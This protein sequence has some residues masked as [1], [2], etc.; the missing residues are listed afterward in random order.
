MIG[1]SGLGFF[2]DALAGRA[3]LPSAQAEARC[4]SDDRQDWLTY[5]E[6]LKRAAPLVERLKP[7]GGKLALIA[8]PNDLDGAL[9]LLCALACGVT[10]ALIDPALGAEAQTRLKDSF[11][12]ELV[13][14]AADGWLETGLSGG[15]ITLGT[16]LLLSTSGT[17]GTARF[18]RLS[19]DA[20]F[21][22]AR[23]IATALHIAKDDAGICHLPLHYSYGLSVL[24]SHLERGAASFVTEAKITSP[25]LWG[26]IGE[27]GGT[28]FPGVPFH[29]ATLAR[30][31]AE[32][33]APP[34][35]VSF[36]QAGGSLDVATRQ[37]INAQI[38]ARGGKFY[39][40]YGQ[41]EAAPRMATLDPARFSAKPDSAGSA[42]KGGRFE[43]VGE[44][45]APLPAGATGEIV[46]YGPNVMW[47]YA[48][49]RADLAKGDENKGRLATGDRGRLDEEGDLF[50]TG[51]NARFAKI[52]GLRVALDEIERRLKPS[53]DVALLAAEEQVRVFCDAKQDSAQI[54]AALDDLAHEYKIP[55]RSFA[56]RVIA[57]IPHL[58]SGK[59]DFKSLRESP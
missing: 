38:A 30:L 41:T 36:T 27:R 51:R 58:P 26:R 44:D 11:A 54:R 17:T 21:A 46:Y 50:I 14:N 42:L 55:E 20:V 2:L 33:M 13:Y 5:A 59:I 15:A 43:I 29:Y 4:L 52:A 35:V 37:K 1:F 22:N 19:R 40:M 57:E 32:R 24:L 49:C 31:G 9:T 10:V 3:V 56:L 16:A 18:V 45:G 47:G 48:T 39:V 23:Q 12:P 53:F 28:H 8:A 25:E 7:F 6:C 34:C